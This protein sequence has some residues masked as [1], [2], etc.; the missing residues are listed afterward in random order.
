M[1]TLAGGVLGTATFLVT[2]SFLVTTPHVSDGAPFLLKDL[3]LLGAALWIAGEAWVA[4]ES[5]R[6]ARQGAAAEEMS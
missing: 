6:A 2:L 5:N 3:T 4:V 1:V